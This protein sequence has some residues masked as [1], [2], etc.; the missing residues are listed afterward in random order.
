MWPLSSD[1]CYVSIDVEADGRIPGRNSML[2]LGAAAFTSD[3]DI[4]ETFSVNL[5]QLPGASEDI[6]T[7]RWWAAHSKAWEACRSNPEAPKSATQRFH[8]WLERQH[9]AVGL[10][11]MVAFPAAYDCDV[12]PVV[13]TPIRG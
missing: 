12:G 4:A 10:P 13:S 3:G 1:E 7:M 8:D 9:A 6:P 5:E 11:V 2:S